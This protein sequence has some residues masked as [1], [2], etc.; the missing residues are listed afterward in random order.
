VTHSSTQTIFFFRNNLWRNLSAIRSSVFLDR[1][2]E[3]PLETISCTTANSTTI[4]EVSP[5]WPFP[6]QILS[7]ASKNRQSQ[8]TVETEPI[9]NGA[10][11]IISNK[12]SFKFSRAADKICRP[13]NHSNA[14][15]SNKVSPSVNGFSFEAREIHRP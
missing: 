11:S 5:K 2:S 4:D 7:T 12:C 15:D 1:I 10:V 9:I 6:V 8:Q 14:F 3:L 13:R